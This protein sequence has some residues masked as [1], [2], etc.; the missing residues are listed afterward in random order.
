MSRAPLALW[1]LLGT[2]GVSLVAAGVA[3]DLDRAELPIESPRSAA[4]D[5]LQ[6]STVYLF[7]FEASEA[8]T[9]CSLS[10]TIAAEPASFEEWVP[11]IEFLKQPQLMKAP[12]PQPPL[13][14]VPVAKAKPTLDKPT[15]AKAAAKAPAA[16]AAPVA[17]APAPKVA[18]TVKTPVAAKAPIAAV[19]AKKVAK[20]VQPVGKIPAQKASPASGPDAVS[21][22]PAKVVAKKVPAN[23]KSAP[24]VENRQLAALIRG[25]N[26]AKPAAP[27]V[28]EVKPI[29]QGYVAV[30]PN[31]ILV[32]LPAIQAKLE[33]SALN[34]RIPQYG[35]DGRLMLYQAFGTAPIR[36]V[37]AS[38]LPWR[39]ASLWS[40][41]RR[42]VWSR[43]LG[44]ISLAAERFAEVVT[45]PTIVAEVAAWGEQAFHDGLY[46]VTVRV[47]H[48]I[49]LAMVPQVQ[50]FS[51]I[52]S[53]GRPKTG[54]L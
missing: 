39:V 31:R 11:K 4:V 35:T 22:K 41:E 34:S 50:K 38:Q 52:R 5:R 10:P 21:A 3:N 8:V 44:A 17:K 27:A 14:P 6:I 36:S 48:N 54:K 15:A 29:P 40:S 26:L 33:L 42:A 51:P 7:C 53:A 28:I 18:V 23:V 12:A 2:L 37:K 20:S 47:R 25:L 1:F 16:V 49:W 9:V 43:V 46:R 13:A 45:L 30:G 32:K 24:A 19:P